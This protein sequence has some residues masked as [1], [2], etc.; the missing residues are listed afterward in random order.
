MKDGQLVVI[1][2]KID[3][4]IREYDQEELVFG[5]YIGKTFDNKVVVLLEDGILYSGAMNTIA[6]AEEQTEGED[7]AQQTGVRE[8]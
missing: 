6:P 5:T 8:E 7:D 3:D 2:G 1:F 4:R